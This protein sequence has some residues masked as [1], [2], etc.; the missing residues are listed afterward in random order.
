VLLEALDHFEGTLMIVSHDRAFIGPLIDTVVEI[1]PD[2]DRPDRGSK[3]V[4]LLG[5]YDDYL[6]R[7]IAEAEFEGAQLREL[8]RE[9]SKKAKSALTQNRTGAD[10]PG[11][12][13]GTAPTFQQKRAWERQLEKLEKEVAEL[14][15][16]LARNQEELVKPESLSDRA[17]LA[18][19]AKK[20]TEMEKLLESKM[21]AWGEVAAKLS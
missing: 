5:S 9:Q 1:I 4:P 10:S 15:E 13:A 3:I 18:E 2:V 20:Q 12:S 17:K 14:E 11:G 6:K 16:K 7:K 19:L 21:D 8:E